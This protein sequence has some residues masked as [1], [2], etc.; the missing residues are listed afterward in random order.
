MRDFNLNFKTNIFF[1]KNALANLPEEVKK[2]GKRV[3]LVY[4][5]SAIKRM[6]LYDKVIALLK[7][8][9]IEV[10]ELGGISPNPRKSELEQGAKL[11]R[12]NGIDLILAVGGGSTIDCS[13][14]IAMQAKYEGSVW[15]DFYA[16]HKG[17]MLK[18]ALPVAS[19]LTLSATGSEMNG[20]SV[21]TNLETEEKYGF[22]HGLLVPRFS[23]LNPEYTY[24]VSKYQTAS[25]SADILSHLFEQ[26]FNPSKDGYLQSRVAEGIMKTV[27]HYA[28]IAIKE[29]ENYEAR[30]NLMWS[31]TLALNGLVNH[32]KPGDWSVHG[33]E[34]ELSAKY[35]IAHG[36]G[37]AILTPHWMKHVLGDENRYRFVEYGMNVWGL[38]GEEE[39][40]IEE[41]IR[42]TSEFFL[43]LDI[44][45]KLSE[46]GID[47]SRIEEMAKNACRYGAIGAMKGLEWQDVMAIYKASM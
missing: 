5:K 2:Y 45:M 33:M 24:S 15:E 11:C 30:A 4:G 22:G 36:V 10:V 46:L 40:I 38:I 43:S 37:L 3:L 41:S 28:P 29:P 26:Y 21:I 6:G 39:Y 31:S 20:N 7:E 34:H 8:N 12:E 19:I 42:R 25:G 44:P 13:K 35:D 27:I 23:I 16:G 32:G 14:G 18:E 1:G 17:H 9:N 47:E